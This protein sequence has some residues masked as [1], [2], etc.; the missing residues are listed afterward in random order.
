MLHRQETV[1]LSDCHWSLSG[2]ASTTAV[3]LGAVKSFPAAGP[4]WQRWQKR[5][6]SAA[7]NLQMGVVSF[8]VHENWCHVVSAV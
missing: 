8:G 2:I 4:S 5:C 3:T 7:Q 6:G 1:A